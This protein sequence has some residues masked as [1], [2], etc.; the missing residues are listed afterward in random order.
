MSDTGKSP[1]QMSKSGFW[2]TT[3]FFAAYYVAALALLRQWRSPHPWS[4]LDIFSGGY[5]LISLIWGG[6]ATRFH[7][8]IFRSKEVLEEAS[9]KKYDPQMLWMISS[10]SLGEL[11][12]FLDYSRWRLVPALEQPALQWLGLA[13]SLTGGLW[14][15]WVDAYLTRH[16]SS[17]MTTRQIL[18]DGPYRF[19]RHP[20]YVAL[21]VSRISFSLALASIL[22]WLFALGWLIAILRRIRL[23]E[24]HLHKIFGAGYD[25]YA[26]R[27]A[28]LVPG[29]F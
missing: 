22:G 9:G 29:I 16:F 12:V 27:T 2:V 13:L 23:E 7:R 11:A 28:R 10:L 3:F 6:A 20:R 24:A 25:A 15:F 26:S 1:E 21:L 17:D 14:L 5:L 19:V 18:K 8:A 4:R